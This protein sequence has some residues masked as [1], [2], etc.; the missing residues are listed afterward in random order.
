MAFNMLSNYC[1]SIRWSW[2]SAALGALALAC[3]GSCRGGGATASDSSARSVVF[4]K[5]SSVLVFPAFTPVPVTQ[6]CRLECDPGVRASRIHS[7]VL[8]P[9]RG[10]PELPQ[11]PTPSAAGTPEASSGAASGGACSTAEVQ[12][13]AIPAAKA[14][15]H[16]D[17]QQRIQQV[18]NFDVASEPSRCHHCL[19]LCSHCLGG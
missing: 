9:C 6:H 8:M 11:S 18:G 4:E 15:A 16:T 12:S 13:P 3:N 5:L 10:A 1:L 14:A 19:L 17:L 2:I 7:G